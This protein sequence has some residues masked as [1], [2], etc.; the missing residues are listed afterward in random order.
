MKRKIIKI[1]IVWGVGFYL[2]LMHDYYIISGLI[3]AICISL[4][5][6]ILHY[7]GIKK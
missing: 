2:N 3:L 4:M 7:E 1:A 5:L 6:W